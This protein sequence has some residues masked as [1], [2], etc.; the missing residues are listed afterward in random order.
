MSDLSVFGKPVGTA[1]HA[2]PRPSTSCGEYAPEAG[3]TS[4]AV[5]DA[6]SR[7]GVQNISG[8][9]SFVDLDQQGIM[10]HGEIAG[11]GTE[12]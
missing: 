2:G 12:E 10:T 1:Q 5:L 7:G 6:H 11:W 4:S 8:G 3:S 9:T